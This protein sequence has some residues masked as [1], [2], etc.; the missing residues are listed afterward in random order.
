[1]SCSSRGVGKYIQCR[2][3]KTD[4]KKKTKLFF[5]IATNSD[6]I[7]STHIRSDCFPWLFC[8]NYLNWRKKKN[9]FSKKKILRNTKKKKKKKKKGNF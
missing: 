9:L 3:K 8:Q 6:E 2:T 1:M 7:A 5:I 4:R